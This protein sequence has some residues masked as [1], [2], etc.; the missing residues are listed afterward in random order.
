M[1]EKTFSVDRHPD[2]DIRIATG[3]VEVKE[4]D[5]GRVNVTVDTSDPNFTVEQRGSSI[6]IS[7]DESLNW[8]S[9]GSSFVVV[10]APPGSDLRVGVASAEVR[11]DLPFD[12]VDIKTASGDVELAGGEN[13]VVKTASGDVRIGHIGNALRFNSAS[14]DLHVSGSVSGTMAISSASGDVYVEESEAT[15][16]INTASGD[17]LIRRFSGRSANFNSM[18]GDVGLGIVRGTSLDLDVNLL[19]GK[20]LLPD[21]EATKSDIERHMSVKA[22]MVSGDLRIQRV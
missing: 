6:V 20:L 15:V 1:I 22:K 18:S 5:P 19:S 16:D 9:R 7:N 8:R 4:G 17:V 2:I 21:P 14:G 13:V 12:K 3:K 10:E 11:V